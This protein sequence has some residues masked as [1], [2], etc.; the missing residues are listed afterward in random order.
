MTVQ[1]CTLIRPL[2]CTQD[3]P[4]VDAAKILK[5]AKQRRLVVTDK[6]SKPVGILSVTDVS[7][8]VV[9]AGKDPKTLTARDVMTAPIHL[10]CTLD[11][12]LTEVWNDMRERESFFVPITK[13]GKLHGIL[14]Y[15]EL[16]RCLQ[17]ELNH[18]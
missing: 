7:N 10:V 18:G 13:G 5:Q 17:E 6:E 11:C 4:L 2:Q 8:K 14:T 3:T 16:M 9:A 15:G 12:E 1:K